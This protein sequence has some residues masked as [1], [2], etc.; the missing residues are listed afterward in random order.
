MTFD[1]LVGGSFK[2][3]G[4]RFSLVGL[5]PSGLLCLFVLALIWSG[6][7]ERAPEFERVAQ[8]VADLRPMETA[9]LAASIL[10]LALVLQPLQLPMVRILEGYWGGSWLAD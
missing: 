7:P 4:T 10:L 6:A 9:G 2:T 5:L 3:F 1:S 8:L